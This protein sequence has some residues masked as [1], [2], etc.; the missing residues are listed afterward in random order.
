MSKTNQNFTA[1]GKDNYDLSDKKSIENLEK[2]LQDI[3]T[4]IMC[5]AIS[6]SRNYL[7]SETT[8]RMAHNLSLALKNYSDKNLILVSSDS[9]YGDESGLYNENSNLNPNSFHGI[10]QVTRELIL[11]NTKLK[12]LAILRCCAIYGLD[13]THNSYG[14]NRFFRNIL[15]S[16]KIKIFGNGLNKRDHVYIEDVVSIIDRVSNTN[17]SGILNVVSGTS[18]S[19]FEV[20]NIVNEIFDSKSEI[21]F[22]GDEGTIREKNFDISKL[23]NSFPEHQIT[24]LRDGLKMIKN[25][26][27]Y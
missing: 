25:K 11:E 20:A 3:S 12:N 27:K 22:T 23:I 19:F 1:I 7:E 9:V 10:A 17:F 2:T 16:E 24:S 6:P 8:S 13:D 18:Y 14:P 5:A 26:V 21:E 15:Q 4:V